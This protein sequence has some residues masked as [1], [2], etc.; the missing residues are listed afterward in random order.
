[1]NLDELHWFVVL[2]RTQH[3]TDAAAELRITQPTLSR[4]L[5][6][7]EERVGTQLFDRV[8]RR[9]RLNAYGEIMLEHAQRSLAEIASAGERIAA[10]RDPDSGTVRLAFLHSLASWLVPD[11]LRRFRN[12]APRVDFVLTQ[13]AAYDI[14][15]FVASGQA[16]LAI[17]APRPQRADFAWHELQTERLCLV[18]PRD[19]RF[20]GR[21]RIRLAEAADEPVIALGEQFAMRHLTDALWAA[22]GVTPRVV[23][24]AIEIPTVEGLVAAGLGVAVVPLPEPRRG[25]PAAAYVPLS[26]PDARRAVGVAWHISR[27]MSPAAGRFAAFLREADHH[28]MDASSRR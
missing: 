13:A 26:N 22:E 1:V 15:D 3:M 8:N 24:E 7:L 21:S 20:A 17:T 4:A 14:V 12:R 27:P 11:L 28:T 19:H 2:A 25:E 16:D 5:G 6:R 23:F 10:L 18:V 9:L